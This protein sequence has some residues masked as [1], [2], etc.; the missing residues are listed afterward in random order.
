M[1]QRAMVTAVVAGWV[2]A[3]LVTGTAAFAATIAPAQPVLRSAANNTEEAPD[4]QQNPPLI[5][6]ELPPVGAELARKMKLPHQLSQRTTN[7]NHASPS[8][9]KNIE[10]LARRLNGTVVRPNEVFSYYRRVGPYTE[11]N[12]YGWGRAFVGDRIVP[13][14]GG[15]VCQGASTLYSALLRTGLPVVERHNHSLKVP[16][17][18]PGEDATV[19]STYLN[20]RFRNNQKTPILIT[21]ATIPEKRL[22]TLAIWGATEVP[23]ITVQHKVLQRYPFRVIRRYNK[24]LD[25]GEEKVLFPGQDGLKVRTWLETKTPKGVQTREVGVDAYRSSPR[26]IEFGR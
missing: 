22:L 6:P 17:L 3:F 26:I 25:K 24:D 5:L 8:Q 19:A 12:G 11:K 20:F 16:Y 23:T 18:P 10:L 13:S 1:T 9:A 4:R 7:Y 14:M 2:T 15:G 21:A